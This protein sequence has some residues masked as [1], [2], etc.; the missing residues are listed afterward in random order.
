M[1]PLVRLDPVE[2]VAGRHQLRPP[3][4]RDADDLLAMALDREIVR[5][6]PISGVTSV[7]EAQAWCR[8][9]SDWDGGTGVQF[10]VYDA[11]EGRL[12]GLVGLHHVDLAL[13]SA[14]IA[15]HTA[16]WARGRGVATA[17]AGSVVSW[18]FGALDLARV[19]LFHAAGNV[20][21]CRVASRLRFAVEGETRREYRYGD[22][23]LHKE[24]S[25]VRLAT[26]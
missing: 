19:E 8:T 21:S 15:Y 10:G 11:T 20:A 9:W 2:I 18:A 22:G 4:L 23:E 17:A 16:P 3:S 25:H 1:E 12:L 7:E 6:G 26:D 13:G 24:H 5:W 14:E